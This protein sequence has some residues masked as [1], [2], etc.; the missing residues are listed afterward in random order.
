MSNNLFR[1]RSPESRRGCGQ[2][3]EPWLLST[4]SQHTADRRPT[5]NACASLHQSI[6]RLCWTRVLCIIETV[7]AGFFGRSPIT[8]ARK[9]AE[10]ICL[11]DPRSGVL[12]TAR[13]V[14]ADRQGFS[15]EQHDEMT[16]HRKSDRDSRLQPRPPVRPRKTRHFQPEELS[17]TPSRDFRE[18][19]EPHSWQ[20]SQSSLRKK[21]T[22]RGCAFR[23]HTT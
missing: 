22:L 20:T 5:P 15:S 3:C 16:P 17:C 14:V 10:P 7:T 11:K 4:S 12:G 18:L 1:I 8:D 6:I 9:D 2:C 23:A 13:I 19:R 21:R